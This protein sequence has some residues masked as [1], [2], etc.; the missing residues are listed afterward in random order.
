M[1]LF[2]YVT[3]AFLCFNLNKIYAQEQG[4][5][6]IERSA[7]KKTFSSEVS[8]N[9]KIAS[10]F[11]KLHA[12][13]EFNGNVLI[14]SADSIIYRNSF[15]YARSTKHELL[16]E[17]IFFQIGSIYKE[18]PA[19]AIMQIQEN[20]GLSVD[21]FITKY[22]PSLPDWAGQI[23]IKHLLQYSSG[24]PNIDW[25]TIVEKHSEIRWDLVQASLMDIDKL[26]FQPGT[27]YL[28]S[29]HNPFLLIRIVEAISGLSFK[30]YFG[31]MILDPFN[32]KG[33]KMVDRF[34]YSSEESDDM[35]MPFDEDFQEETMKY[36]LPIFCAT[37]GGI[38]HWFKLLDEFK[39]IS[40][41]SLQFLSKKA[42]EGENIQ[43]PIGRGDWESE[44]L[45]LHLHHGSQ[46]QFECLVR[47][48][49]EKEIQIVLFTNQKHQNLHEI[50]AET[51]KMIQNSKRLP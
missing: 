18:F 47:N 44:D 48:H 3:I 50:A 10:Y 42:V 25:P 51:M 15:G 14:C 9:N 37:T 32:I 22:I 17:D 24:L 1:K 30:E 20:G 36:Q 11:K 23:K 19:V 16:N 39:I 12:N 13:Q 28:Y 27:D 46:G 5:I 49:K 2:Q 21:D 6:K 7:D 43:S 29:N 38:H 4:V 26:E 41:E 33:V 45:L 8:L 31:Q 35:A 34:P 40:R